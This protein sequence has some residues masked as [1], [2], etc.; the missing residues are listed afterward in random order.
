MFAFQRIFVDTCTDPSCVEILIQLHKQ[1]YEKSLKYLHEKV[2][3][4]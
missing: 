1:R 2:T 3:P 4:S